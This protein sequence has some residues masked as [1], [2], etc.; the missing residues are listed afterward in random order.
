M[1]LPKRCPCGSKENLLYY[2]MFAEVRSPYAGCHSLSFLRCP[3]CAAKG[4]MTLVPN[5]ELLDWQK[6]MESTDAAKRIRYD[7]DCINRNGPAVLEQLKREREYE[8]HA[9]TC[10]VTGPRDCPHCH[11]CKKCGGD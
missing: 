10:T 9:H 5:T 3:D 11:D 6:E 4:R 8:D 1:S 7:F 2:R